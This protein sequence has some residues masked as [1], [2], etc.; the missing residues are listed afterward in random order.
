METNGKYTATA[1]FQQ[2]QSFYPPYAYEPKDDDAVLKAV[3]D[4]ERNLTAGQVGVS[5]DIHATTLG[6][7]DAIEKGT[8]ASSKAI[9]RNTNYVG[10]AVER[11]HGTI[12]TAIEKVAGETRLTATVNDAATRQAN[13][14]TAIEDPLGVRSL[15]NPLVRLLHVERH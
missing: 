13:A 3:T 4:S 2:W 7:R 15:S 14:D 6:L 10:S 1:P 8:L 9:D 12:M 11:G 5:K